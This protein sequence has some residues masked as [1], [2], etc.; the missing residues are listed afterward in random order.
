MIEG[1]SVVSGSSQIDLTQ[2]T[3]YVNGIKERLNAEGVI[4]GSYQITNGSGLLSSSNE[5]FEQ[6]SSSVDFRLDTLQLFT[7]SQESKNS[8]L[9]TY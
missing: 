4:S 3:N 6:F 7:S 1:D 8:T 2:T 9:A 5:N